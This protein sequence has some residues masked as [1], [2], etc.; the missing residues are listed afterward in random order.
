MKQSFRNRLTAINDVVLVSSAIIAILVTLLDFLGVLD[1][2]D[3]LSERVEIITLLSI[4]LL[5]ISIVLER[6]THLDR[7]QE[8]LDSLISSYTFGAQ[9]LEDAE[10]V[11][12]QMERVTRRANESIM[13]LGSKSRAIDYLKTIEEAV[14]HRKVI[15]YRLLDGTYIRHELHDHLINVIAEPN[16]NI[17]WTYREK[18]GNLVVTENECVLAFP[19]PYLNKF[20]GLW[21]P[22]ESNSRRYTQYFLEVYSKCLAVRTNKS[23]EALCL[24]CSPE[25]AGKPVEIKRILEEELKSFLD[26]L[27]DTEP[28]LL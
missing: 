12:M 18:F 22:G 24:E 13:A 6:R 27:G 17:A 2:I 23:I 16:V 15:H 19:A 4:S 28:D 1:Q 3:W 20:S 7:I 10:T 9:Y 14:K 5:L 8:T 26:A 21:L 11:V 25:T